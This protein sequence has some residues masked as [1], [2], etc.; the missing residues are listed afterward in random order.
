MSQRD[1]R[2]VSLG[3]TRH[4]HP[5]LGG[6]HI[7]PFGHVFA[8]PGHLAAAARALRAGGFDHPFDPGQMQR[9]V[10][11]DLAAAMGEGRSAG[12]GERSLRGRLWNMLGAFGRKVVA[13]GKSTAKWGTHA[14]LTHD[15]V[16]WVLGNETII[17]GWLV[18]TQGAASGWFASV[19][20]NLKGML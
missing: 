11:D 15:F 8:D 10:A 20:A 17:A 19:V 1:R 9:Q 6:D 18:L 14:I 5:E 7:E 4:E 3:P 2:L 16:Q 13:T 12:I